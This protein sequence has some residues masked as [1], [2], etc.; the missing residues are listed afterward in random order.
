MSLPQKRDVYGMGC[1]MRERF[2]DSLKSFVRCDE[3]AS[4]VEYAVALVVVTV[5]GGVIFQLGGTISA[6]IGL[7]AGAF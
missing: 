7:S 2:Y 3:G 5:I 4:L 1:V 6:I